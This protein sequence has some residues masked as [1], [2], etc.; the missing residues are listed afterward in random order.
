MPNPHRPAPPRRT[1]A[2]V[3]LA[4]VA[5]WTCGAALL[6]LAPARVARADEAVGIFDLAFHGD[7][8]PWL[9]KL[10]TEHLRKGLTETGLTVVDQAKMKKTLA[11]HQ[12]GCDTPACRRAVAGDLN[13]R[14][15]VGGTVSESERSYSIAL[16][17]ALGPSGEVAARQKQQCDICGKDK[18]AGAID[19]AASALRAKIKDSSTRLATI[20]VTTL[21]AGAVVLVDG[22]EVGHGPL[23]LTLPGGDH[24]IK[25]RAKGFLPGMVKVK[26]VAGLQESVEVRL[27]ASGEPGGAVDHVL[28]PL[29]WATVAMGLGGIGA[30][31]A[32]LVIDGQGVGCPDAGSVP[33][34]LVQ[35]EERRDTA[36]VGWILTGAGLATAAAGGYLVW[37]AHDGASRDEPTREVRLSPGPGALTLRGNF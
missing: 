2:H 1:R 6:T 22:D 11:R 30:G 17:I 13:A 34:D 35:C 27:L 10:L 33:G 32:L 7:I 20:K 31:V 21:P 16:W 25:A 36:S 14:Y 19:L 5:L 3:A 15:L 37:R 18:V 4:H 23:T 9:Q 29:G 26:A 8:K 28:R 12:G 24:E